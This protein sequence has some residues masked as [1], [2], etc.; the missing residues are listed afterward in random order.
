MHSNPGFYFKFLL[1]FCFSRKSK[2]NNNPYMYQNYFLMFYKGRRKTTRGGV[3]VNIFINDIY[4]KST[5][6]K[7]PNLLSQQFTHVI[8]LNLRTIYLGPIKFK[9]VASGFQHIPLIIF[10]HPI[11]FSSQTKVWFGLAIVLTMNLLTRK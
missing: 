3:C 9:Y 10:E 6:T 1:F 5:H 2:N 7:Y 11:P 4:V 8:W